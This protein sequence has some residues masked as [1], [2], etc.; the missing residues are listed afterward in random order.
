MITLKC[1][2]CT[3]EFYVNPPVLHQKRT[4]CPSCNKMQLIEDYP[5][6][7]VHDGIFMTKEE[8]AEYRKEVNG[9]INGIN[10]WLNE[11]GK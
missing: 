7:G 2:N 1:P 10:K 6:T 3:K 5:R 4:R 9:V 8:R 11:V